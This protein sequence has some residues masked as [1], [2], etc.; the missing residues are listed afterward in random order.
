MEALGRVPTVCYN[1]RIKKSV[2]QDNFIISD[3]KKWYQRQSKW[4][5]I[6][7]P[8]TYKVQET[9]AYEH[10]NPG[11][12]RIRTLELLPLVPN[13]KPLTPE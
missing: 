9:L 2:M 8:P 1:L 7:L 13:F 4:T 12:L 5:G 3:L 6:P 10:R 11:P